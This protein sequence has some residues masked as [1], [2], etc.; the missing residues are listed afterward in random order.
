MLAISTGRKFCKMILTWGDRLCTY[1]SYR[2]NL[3]KRIVG[4]LLASAILLLVI[5]VIILIV[6]CSRS[7]KSRDNTKAEPTSPNG[8]NDELILAHTVCPNYEIES[9]FAIKNEN[10]NIIKQIFVHL[11]FRSVVMG[12]GIQRIYLR[13]IHA[14]RQKIIGPKDWEN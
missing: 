10:C 13:M 12:H 3:S 8:T 4:L 5:L 7:S 9:S 11:N 1:L 14:N 6:V 2:F